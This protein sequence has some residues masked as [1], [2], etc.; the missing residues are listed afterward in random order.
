MTFGSN[1]AVGSSEEERRPSLSVKTQRMAFYRVSTT[2]AR[3][4]MWTEYTVNEKPDIPR[5]TAGQ[6]S[7]LFVA[8]GK[9]DDVTDGRSAIRDEATRS[10]TGRRS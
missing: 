10:F 1:D 4:S 9:A 8:G 5:R 2:K 3:D 7:V 6:S